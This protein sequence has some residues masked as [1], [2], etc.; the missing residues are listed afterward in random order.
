MQS[1]T[2]SNQTDYSRDDRLDWLAE[3]ACEGFGGQLAQLSDVEIHL[4]YSQVSQ[5]FMD[6]FEKLERKLEEVHKLTAES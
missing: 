1:E 4:L 2:V 5:E 3:C 6:R